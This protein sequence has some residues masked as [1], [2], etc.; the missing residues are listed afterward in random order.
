MSLK[1]VACVSAF[2]VVLAMASGIFQPVAAVTDPLHFTV[3]VQHLALPTDSTKTFFSIIIGR[4]F[5]GLLPDEIDRIVVKGPDGYCPLALKDFH[6]VPENREFWAT[7]PG[8][9][10]KGKYVITVTAGDTHGTV[11]RSL[12]DIHRVPV[13]HSLKYTSDESG[14]IPT[15][16]PTFFWDVDRNRATLY[17]QLQLKD[18]SGKIIFRSGF[19][20]NT[21]ALQLE[22]NVLEPNSVYYWRVRV[23]DSP[24]WMSTRNRSQTNWHKIKTA[25][26]LEYDYIQPPSTDDG[27]QTDHIAAVGVNPAPIQSMLASIINHTKTNVHSVLLVKDG[28]LVLEEYFEGFNRDDLHLTASVTKSVNSILFGQV[29][30]LGLIGDINLSAWAFFP[31]YDNPLDIKEKKKV[32]LR[33]LLTMSAGLEWDYLS[34]PLE[35]PQYITNQMVASGDPIR[36]ILSRRVIAAPGSVYNYNDGLALILGE[37]IRRVVGK[38]ADEF[39]KTTLFGPLGIRKYSWTRTASGLVETHGGLRL[40]LRD[41]GKIGQLVLQEGRWNG[42]QVVSGQWL[43]ESTREHIRGDGVG[44]GYQWRTV[45]LVR[46]G[47]PRNIIWASGYGGQRIFILPALKTVMVITSK[48]L[49]NRGGN[50]RAEQQFVTYILPSLLTSDELPLHPIFAPTHPEKYVG[51]YKEKSGLFGGRIVLEQNRLFLFTEIHSVE[52]KCELK[53]ISEEVLIGQ[54]QKLGTFRLL[55]KG[56]DTVESC[57]VVLKIGLKSFILK[58]TG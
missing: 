12:A 51:R 31:E 52:E 10:L 3:A 1:R 57:Q 29:I 46:G 40:R 35:D 24:D 14:D 20:K 30:D 47:R 44:Y 26:M 39:A 16:R 6:F 33:H 56:F 49:H 11:E 42:R 25:R 41:M 19:Y 27:W 8:S 36:F 58:K 32:K 43:D 54:S 45:K 50:F 37:I 17:H 9:P 4:S 53:P 48:V 7:L 21:S 23:F 38:P 18:S 22:K 13:P 28:K 34:V 5:P 55:F 2:L 15:N